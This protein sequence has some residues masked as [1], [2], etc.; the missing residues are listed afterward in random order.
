MKVFEVR[1][2]READNNDEIVTTIQ[3]VTSSE[4]DIKQVFNYFE[5]CEEYGMELK[6]VREVLTISLHIRKENE[7]PIP[8]GDE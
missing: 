4:D 6:G 2:E 3:Y 8:P 1:T 7:T 5:Y